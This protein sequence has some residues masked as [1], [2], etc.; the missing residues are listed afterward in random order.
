MKEADHGV[1]QFIAVHL[2]VSHNDARFGYK[3]QQFCFNRLDV[4]HPVMNKENLSIAVHFTQ[5]RLP[6]KF[7]VEPGDTGFYWLPVRWRCF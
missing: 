2:A 5:N 6:D 3:L 1:F 4:V 7:F